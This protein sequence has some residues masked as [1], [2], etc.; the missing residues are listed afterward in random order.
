M[1][2]SLK[3]VSVNVIIAVAPVTTLTNGLFQQTFTVKFKGNEQARRTGNPGYSTKSTLMLRS[4]TQLIAT[5]S[6]ISDSGECLS[7]NSD[8][9][10]TVPL[11]LGS[12]MQIK[13]KV[14][15]DKLA[16]YC[17]N[18]TMLKQI[19]SITQIGIFAN[20][21]ISTG[22]VWLLSLIVGLD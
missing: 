12:S 8:T 16:E 5:L 1:D 17:K 2:G 22:E 10:L 21:A 9:S 3:I 13:C 19:D 15:V 7:T 20:A 6:G 14:P 4:T 11:L 18:P